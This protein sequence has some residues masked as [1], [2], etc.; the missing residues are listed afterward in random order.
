MTNYDAPLVPG[1]YQGGC[2]DLFEKSFGL[3]G[4]DILYVG[5]HIYGDIVR[6]KKDCKWRTALVIE[7]LGDEIEKTRK[8]KPFQDQI[9]KL[10][11]QKYPLEEK[12]VRLISDEI[13]KAP[14]TTRNTLTRFKKRLSRWIAR[15]LH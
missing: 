5:D 7:E 11:G 14:L 13:E 12:L 1:I 15:L 4:E 3:S 9:R 6:L 8:V 10:M 2:A